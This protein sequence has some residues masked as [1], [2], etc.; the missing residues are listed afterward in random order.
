MSRSSNRISGR[1]PGRASTRLVQALGLALSASA[2][3]GLV[4]VETVSA[5][6]HPAEAVELN[7]LDELDELEMDSAEAISPVAVIPS[8][9][10]AEPSP[11]ADAPTVLAAAA[12][13]ALP[14]AVVAEAEAPSIAMVVMPD[15]K[16]MRLDKARREL[17]Q[18]GLRMAARDTW[19][20]RI[21]RSW[22]RDFKVRT[23]TVEAGIEVERGTKV[24]VKA[25]E[26]YRASK[27]Y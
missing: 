26:R 24:R 12:P 13:S 4:Y 15:L 11:T 5:S 10:P 8:A 19:G 20:E 22:Y 6:P 1:T 3:T 16:G 2:I 23:Q 27:G 9:T 18:L 14:V 21:E 7:E 25:R 17:K